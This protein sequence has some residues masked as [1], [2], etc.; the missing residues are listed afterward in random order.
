ML[1]TARDTSVLSSWRTVSVSLPETICNI[2]ELFNLPTIF[3]LQ[4]FNLVRADDAM[5]QLQDSLK[6][7]YGSTELILRQITRSATHNLQPVQYVFDM[8][9]QHNRT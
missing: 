2:L 6:C 9:G 8:Q 4:C 1:N 5:H 3:V 7:M